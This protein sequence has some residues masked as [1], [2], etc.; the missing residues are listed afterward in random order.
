[1]PD[2]Q[3]VN[4]DQCK[5]HLRERVPDPFFQTFIEPLTALQTGASTISLVVP[6]ARLRHHIE[7]RYGDLLK[8]AVLTHFPGQISLVRI[9]HAA[10]AGHGAHGAH[11]VAESLQSAPVSSDTVISVSPTQHP[12]STSA[13]TTSATAATLTHGMAASVAPFA[14]DGSYLPHPAVRND[15]EAIVRMRH[16][17]RPIILTGGSGSG[18]T[19]FARLWAAHFMGTGDQGRATVLSMQD[20]LN[21]FVHAIRTQTTMQ[22]K[23]DLRDNRLLIIDDLQLLKPSAARCQEE[24]RSLVDDFEKSEGLLV[25]LSDREPSQ[26]TLQKDLKS[27]LLMA[28]QVHLLY[29]DIETRKRILESDLAADGLQLRQELL[30]HLARRIPQD[31]RLLRAAVHRLRFQGIAPARLSLDDVDRLCGQLYQTEEQNIPPARILEAVGA[32]L[33]VSVEEIQGPGKE[34]RIA[35]ARHIA[36]Y[37]CST[38]SG[39]TLAEVAR[40]TKRKDHTGVLYA[41]NRLEKLME[42]DLFLRRQV[43]EIRDRLLS[44]ARG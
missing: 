37:L 13:A 9:E 32:Y 6:E 22:W 24:L 8:E 29:P 2:A 42:Q 4:W 31:V 43:E 30:D 5:R 11:A 27:R 15:L 34:K 35:L 20:L 33:R 40:V 38:M 1:M 23:K 26:L 25:F 41:L 39:L 7:M 18:K 36:S 28:H 14:W 16:G 44:A 3:R 10:E 12:R 17:F 19:A 21:G